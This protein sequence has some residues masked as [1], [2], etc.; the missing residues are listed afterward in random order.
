MKIHFTNGQ[1]EN[2]IHADCRKK[3]KNEQNEKLI[4]AEFPCNTPSY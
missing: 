1:I 4:K 3:S 2:S